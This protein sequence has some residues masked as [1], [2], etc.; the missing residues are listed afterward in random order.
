M[1]R[2]LLSSAIFVAFAQRSLGVRGR[3][4]WAPDLIH[5]YGSQWLLMRNSGLPWWLWVVVP[6]DLLLGTAGRGTGL[7]GG[8]VGT[9]REGPTGRYV[10]GAR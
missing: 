5:P 4:A 8:V 1:L 3:R 9:A 7:V 10:G 6:G 2:A